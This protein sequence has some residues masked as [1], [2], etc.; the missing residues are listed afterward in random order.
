MHDRSALNW[1]GSSRIL[2]ISCLLVCVICS[3][4]NAQDNSIHSPGATWKRYRNVEDAGFSQDRLLKAIHN[5]NTHDIAGMLVVYDGALVLRYGDIETR[6]MC[7]SI[8]KSL[9]SLMFGMYDIDL[10]KTL[11][12]LQIDDSPKLTELE[13]QATIADL[14]KSRSGIYHRAAYEPNSMKQSRPSRGTYKPGE[15][16]WYNNW[17]F[18]ALLTI[19]EKETGKKFFEAFK[20]RIADPLQLEDFRLRDGYYHREPSSIHPA[21]PFRL[22][23]RDMAR[24]GWLVAAE[25]KWGDQQIV[26]ANWIHESTQP[27]SKIPTWNKYHGYGYLWWVAKQQNETIISALGNGNNSIDVVPGR[28]L[29]FVFRANTFKGKTIRAEDRWQIINDIIAAHDKVPKPAPELVDV[30]FQNPLPAG[31]Q[32][33]QLS[34]EYLKTFPIDL[35]RQLPASLPQSIRDQKIRIDIKPKTENTS[36]LVLVTRRP[37]AM[38]LDLLPLKRDR[39]WIEGLNEIGVIQRDKNN[40]PTKFLMKDDLVASWYEASKTNNPSLTISIS[41]LLKNHFDYVVVDR[42]SEINAGIKT[43]VSLQEDGQKWPYEGNYRVEGKVPFTYEMG[44]T[45]LVCLALLYGSGDDDTKANAAFENG[46][47]FILDN[48]DD[49]RMATSNKLEYDMRVLAQAYSLLLLS[50]VNNQKPEHDRNNAIKNGMQQL[51]KSLIAEQMDDGGWNYQGRPVHASFVTAS[52]VEALTWANGPENPIDRG[53]FRR[54]TNALAS[55]RFI[56]G[57][58]RYYGTHDSNAK[59]ER[60]DLLPGSIGR[61]SICESMLHLHGA[62]SVNRIQKSID[63]FHHHWQQLENRRRKTG[64]H[65]GPFLVA[66][67]YF[68]YGH[69]YVAQAIELLPVSQRGAERNRLYQLLMRTKSDDGTWND[70]IYPRARSYGTAMVMLALMSDRIGVPPRLHNFTETDEHDKP[71]QRPEKYRGIAKVM[72]KNVYV[73]FPDKTI[74]NVTPTPG[75]G[76][77]GGGCVHPDGKDVVFP[78]AAWG[79][80]RIWKYTCSNGN[81]SALTPASFASINPSYSPDGKQIVFVADRD[82]D[83][84]RFDMFEV[85]RT[86]PHDDGFR[87]GISSAS[88]LYIMDSDGANIRRLTTGEHYDTRPSFSPDGKTVVFLSSRDSNTLHIWTVPADGSKGPSKLEMKDNPWA[89]RPYFSTDGKEIFF[90]SGITD[91]KYEPRGRHTLCRVPTTGGQWRVVSNDTLGKASHGPYPG[92]K[93][94]ALWYHAFVNN[95]WSIYRLP[96]NG[97]EPQRRIPNGFSMAHVAHPTISKNG[98][99]AFDSRSFIDTTKK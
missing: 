9:M 11:A 33:V 71:I 99:I 91:G 67:Y 69:R 48:L 43:L 26:P 36:K 73:M 98:F 40:K 21:Y 76:F 12:E 22:S 50:H 34:D 94:D 72:V 3:A 2:G 59:R 35:S 89:G 38:Q 96:L 85:G 95:L 5:A 68:Y 16:W 27:H 97:G 4:L 58:F 45:S 60:Q 44:G 51:T 70:R 31:L 84:P 7:H 46:L 55:S 14:L 13:K 74:K 82:L 29:V 17:D 75:E 86:K 57:G 87:G 6:Y 8:R 66:P 10:N 54:A 30:S 65:D 90:F 41:L 28:K 64:T 61:A 15:H 81:I 39:F 42:Q 18:N 52:V 20:K 63:A 78:G 23:A 32:A 79:H 53:V 83:N 88:N 62:G 1:I 24:I 19:F 47:S 56:D 25:G 93:G 80:A 77:Y 92:P 49:P 37:P